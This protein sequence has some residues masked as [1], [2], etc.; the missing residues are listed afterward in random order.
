[1][2]RYPN[3]R[4]QTPFAHAAA[5]RQALGRLIEGSSRFNC[6]LL[7]SYPNNGLFHER[8][9]DI[10]TLLKRHYA[11]VDVIFADAP[12][13]STLGGSQ[14]QATVTVRERLYLALP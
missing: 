10:R 7:L 11:I 4:Y 3:N 8:G 9:G 6:A 12:R 1:M 14:G 13:H 2:G 5:V